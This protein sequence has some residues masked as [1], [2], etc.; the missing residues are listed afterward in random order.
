MLLN[1]RLLDLRGV[2]LHE[3]NINTG[4]ALTPAQL[5]ALVRLDA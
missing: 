5:D 2:N 1:G 3:Q 4:A